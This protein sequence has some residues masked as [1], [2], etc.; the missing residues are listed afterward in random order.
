MKT[1]ATPSRKM[2]IGVCGF[3][4][5]GSLIW[6]MLLGVGSSFGG[7]SDGSGVYQSH[8]V[9]DRLPIFSFIALALGFLPA[10][11]LRAALVCLGIAFGSY[12]YF[13]IG[14]LWRDV[15]LIGLFWGAVI[16]APFLMLRFS[17]EK[18]NA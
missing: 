2:F 16:F 17:V 18:K 5:I 11:R 10:F 12:V 13:V 8:F 14:V 7:W 3:S 4:V 1:D 9:R 15:G 6:L